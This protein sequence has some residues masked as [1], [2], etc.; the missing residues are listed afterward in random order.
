MMNRRFNLLIVSSVAGLLACAA[1]AQSTIN[2]Q[3][4][5]TAG[6]TNF[7]GE[8]HFKFVLVNGGGDGLW[9]NDGSPGPGEPAGSVDVP[10]NNGLFNVQLGE[11][12]ASIPP[13]VPHAG[14]LQLRTWFSAGAAAFEQLAPDVAL[15]PANFGQIDTGPTIIVDSWG[16]GDFQDIQEAVNYLADHQ[17]YSGILVMPGYYAL[18]APLTFPT[19]R[20]EYF[21]RGVGDRRYV[22]IEN[23]TGPAAIIQRVRMENICL[24]GNPAFS[25]EDSEANYW[26]DCRR[27]VFR[28]QGAGG[29]TVS[30]GNPGWV[31]LF[32]C[33]IENNQDESAVRLSG[34]A[35]FSA[36]HCDLSV[37]DDFG[38]NAQ[39]HAVE[40]DNLTGWPTFED[41][42]FWTRDGGGAALRVDGGN[43]GDFKRCAFYSG[44]TLTN[45]DGINVFDCSVNGALT[46]VGGAGHINFRRSRLDTVQLLT[47][48]ASTWFD[49]CEQWVSGET[50]FL[51]EDTTGEIRIED[52]NIQ[53][54]DGIA[55]RVSATDACP[56]DGSVDV[57]AW[58]CRIM[59]YGSSPDPDAIAVSSDPS[60]PWPHASVSLSDGEVSGLR[61]GIRCEGGSVD[62]T[63][64]RIDGQ[65]YGISSD[66][67]GGEQG[68]INVSYSS[69]SGQDCAIMATNANYCG[70]HA[71]ECDVYGSAAILANGLGFA[72]VGIEGGSVNGWEGDAIRVSAPTCSVG[73][74]RAN[75]AGK[76]TGVSVEAL[77]GYVDMVNAFVNGGEGGC[78]VATSDTNSVCTILGGGVFAPGTGLEFQGGRLVADGAI[79][80]A[81]GGAAVR[82]REAST[83]ALLTKCELMGMGD[84]NA[85]PALVLAGATPAAAPSARVHACL[86]MPNGG[87][88]DAAHSIGLGG[89]LTN[90]SI[91]LFDTTMPL[92]IDPRIQ[93][94]APLET[95]AY[96]NRVVDM[97]H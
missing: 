82:L 50:A 49:H 2:Y 61:D 15:R 12:M 25:D 67:G 84:G 58:R 97:L 36:K 1:G 73:I 62:A 41:C 57:K 47:R 14:G 71:R 3:G 24:S 59:S 11:D 69:I 54:E 63:R 13:M 51:V 34:N 94:I 68:S 75:V 38:N 30:L 65:R 52:C 53:S 92:P 22:T 42:S 18:S 40:I 48:T 35:S 66:S 85:S 9:S 87:T 46:V 55:L 90:A 16:T 44:A 39:G 74:S 89:A 5:I 64:C 7:T 27:C 37:W 77:L 20:W 19:N 88:L 79:F 8:G 10:V 23:E 32:E 45:T 33:D 70:A 78:V 76:A 26:V 60:F 95:D 91:A 72:S 80:R 17:E 43:G 6:G 93:K 31:G 28:R 4:R 56:P 29:P 96:G 83:W 81:G 21:L 86:F